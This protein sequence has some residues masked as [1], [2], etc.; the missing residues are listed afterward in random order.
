MASDADYTTDASYR[1][2]LLEKYNRPHV[3]WRRLLIWLRG[4]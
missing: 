4:R 3:S 2:A 1:L